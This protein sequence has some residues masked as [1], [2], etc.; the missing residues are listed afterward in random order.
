MEQDPL[1][2]ELSRLPAIS[3]DPVLTSR[4]AAAAQSALSEGPQAQAA[5]RG[6]AGWAFFEVVLYRAAIPT[7]LAGATLIYLSWA[8]GAASQLY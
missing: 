3:P 7:A 8:I 6:V 4:V 1:L 2:K 5:R